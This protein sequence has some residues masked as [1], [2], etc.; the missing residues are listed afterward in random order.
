MI[1]DARPVRVGGAAARVLPDEVVKW[2]EPWLAGEAD[3]LED[4]T[5]DLAKTLEGLLGLP[6][7]DDTK[8]VVGRTCSVEEDSAARPVVERV[9]APTIGETR[10][11]LVVLLLGP[12]WAVVH[13]QDRHLDLLAG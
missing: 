5:D 10:R 2:E 12:A 7:V 4:G 11:D 13:H 1:A 6:H 9:E 3:L 8:T